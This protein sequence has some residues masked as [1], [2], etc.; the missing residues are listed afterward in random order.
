MKQAVSTSQKQT[1][2][3]APQQALVAR[4]IQS[5]NE[6]LESLIVAETEKNLVLE[7][8]DRPQGDYEEG[9]DSGAMSD[10][11]GET[12]ASDETDDGSLSEEAYR[13]E[14]GDIDF[15]DYD[16]DSPSDRVGLS[17]DSDSDTSWSPLAN[18]ATDTTSVEDLHR[19]I[20]ECDITPDEQFIAHY[21][22][23]SL[24][25]NGYLR[26][27]IREIC[28][29]LALSQQ[30]DTTEETVERVLVDVVQS[31]DPPGIGARDLRECMLLQ[32][33]EKSASPEATLAYEIVRRCYDDLI[34][35]GF[36][37]IRNTLGITER[38]LS[39]AIRVIE[40]ITPKPGGMKAGGD[41][42][43]SRAAQIKP[44]FA[45]HSQD[46]ELYVQLLDGYLPAVRINAEYSE[47]FTTLQSQ[48]QKEHTRT[49]KNREAATFLRENLVSADLFLD[50]LR[51]RRQTLSRVIKVIAALQRDYFLSGGVPE[52]LRPMVLQ[53]VS[54]KSGYDISTISRVSN[55]K[56]I[57]TDFGIIAVSSLFTAAV[58]TKQGDLISNEAIKQTL[59]QLIDEED[60]RNP[61]AD[62]ALSEMLDK[63]GM[64]VA[65]R[66]VAKYREQLGYPVARLRKQI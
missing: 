61:L 22:I 59:K 54:E 9:E 49:S 14:S 7:L 51:Q 31:L 64:S 55:S 53:D 45:I 25:D 11:A 41:R 34:K 66:T 37:R 15:F 29:D 27:S 33:Q 10:Y 42:M 47:M 50:A 38:Q 35:K 1:I 21:L 60:K 13:S 52:K 2:R 28:D 57:D 39:G 40:H 18:Y 17:R 48:V 16:D 43:E 58:A 3:F 44:D 24:D 20:D 63:K 46:G 36:D 65:R 56:Y 8:E 5:T 32:L 19:Q 6:E 4:I 30:Y 23:N 26:P 12:E 62:D